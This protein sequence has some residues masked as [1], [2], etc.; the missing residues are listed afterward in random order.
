[1]EETHDRGD[2]RD[3]KGAD[4]FPR[5]VFVEP[6]RPIGYEWELGWISTDKGYAIEENSRTV[7]SLPWRK[8]SLTR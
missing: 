6:V 1:V 3:G 5:R 7:A 4:A 2:E 8:R